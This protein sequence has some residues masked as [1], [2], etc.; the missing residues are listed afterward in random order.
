MWDVSGD[1]NS[2]PHSFMANTL[3]KSHEFVCHFC[4]GHADDFAVSVLVVLPKEHCYVGT[5]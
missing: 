3:L 5:V 1:L 4:P 2:G